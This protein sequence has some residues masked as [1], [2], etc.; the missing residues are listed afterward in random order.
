MS[1]WQVP[2]LQTMAFM[3]RFYENW[4][5][6]RLPIREAFQKTQLEMRDRFFDPYAW[7]GFVLIQ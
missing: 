3:T 5:S 7:A 4:I 1:L 6:E 2:D